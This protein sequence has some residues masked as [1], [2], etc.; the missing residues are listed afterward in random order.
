MKTIDIAGSDMS[1]PPDEGE[2]AQAVEQAMQLAETHLLAG[3]IGEAEQLYGAVLQLSPLHADANRQLGLLALKAAEVEASLPFFAAALEARPDL[4]ASWLDYVEA[5][6]L[7]GQ[8]V[9]AGQVLQFGR[10][11]GLDNIWADQLARRLAGGAPAAEQ[12]V[13]APLDSASSADEAP[14]ERPA[15]V[16]LSTLF[17]LGCYEEVETSARALTRS[18][19]NDG[20]GWKLL[21]AALLVQHRPREALPCMQKAARLSPG[22]VGVQQN[23]GRILQELGNLDAAESACRNAVAMAQ[24]DMLAHSDLIMIQ[25]YHSRATP[26]RRLAGAKRFGKVASTLATAP[27]KGWSCSKQAQRLRIGLV[28]ADLRNHPVGFFLEEL[29]AALDPRRV[30]LIAYPTVP[31]VDWMTS[32][33]RPY[34]AAWRPIS[35]MDNA[36]AAQLIESD[37]VHVLFDLGGHTG[38]NRLPVFAWRPAPVQV[39]W[40]GYFATTG[41]AEM[42]YLL[43][44]PHVAPPGEEGEF[45]ETLWRMPDSYLCFTEPREDVSVTPLSAL[46]NGYVTFGCFNNLAKMTDAV[47]ALWSRVLKAVPDSRL[48][49]KTKQLDDAAVRARTLARFA[50]HGIS[51]ERISMSGTGTRLAMLEAYQHV[52]IALDPFPYPGGTTSM[53][54]LWMAVPIV[55]RR[56][57]HFLSHLGESILHN[58]GLPDWIASDDDDYVAIARSFASDVDALAAL[59]GRLRQQVVNS[60]LYDA[61]RF[62]RHFEDA[63]WG[64]WHDKSTKLAESSALAPGEQ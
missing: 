60:P 22:D 23:L 10:E 14:G 38:N 1:G 21:G 45:T 19:P 34:F 15:E 20:Y 35:G 61:R 44:D 46:S 42:D 3:R 58:A 29:L 28:S 39:S 25:S 47:V 27:F 6:M 16:D 52:D 4:A 11:H 48:S 51:A 13:I 9:L 26:A 30:E 5:L 32:R 36:A 18:W 33:L 31:C 56:G 24:T 62:A 49:L 41:M 54:A 8:E 64:M 7:A 2:I 40:L 57:T 53:E 43:A 63:V 37:G 55:T 17:E 59:R 50:A 12:A